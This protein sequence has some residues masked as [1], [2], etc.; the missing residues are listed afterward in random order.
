MG[1]VLYLEEIFE[2]SFDG[3]EM[4]LSIVILLCLDGLLIDLGVLVVLELLMLGLVLLA[5]AIVHGLLR[6]RGKDRRVLIE[7][8]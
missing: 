4:A 8:I 6:F 2:G 3:L 7:I 5:E 1:L